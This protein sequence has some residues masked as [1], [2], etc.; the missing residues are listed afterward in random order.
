MDETTTRKRGRD[1][2]DEEELPK[3]SS[4]PGAHSDS[5]RKPLTPPSTP[6]ATEPVP[7][8]ATSTEGPADTTAAAEKTSP[9]AA[10]GKPATTTPGVAASQKTAD[11]HQPEPRRKAPPQTAADFLKR[12]QRPATNVATKKQLKKTAK[13]KHSQPAGAPQARSSSSQS[14]PAATPATPPQQAGP[15]QWTPEASTNLA[16]A[17]EPAGS[18]PEVPDDFRL[19]MSRAAR[20]RNKATVALPADPAVA[21][22]VLFRPSEKDGSFAKESR[23]ALASAL[24]TIEGVTAVR[25]NGKRNVV[26]ADAAMQSCLEVLLATTQLRGIPVAARLPADRTR[27]T[28]FV[29]GV[30]GSHSDAELL[31][32]IQSTIPVLAATRQESTVVL[33]FAGPLPPESVSIFRLRFTVRPARPR[34][35]Q[36]KQCGRLGHVAATCRWPNSCRN[37]SRMHPATEPCSSQARCTNCGGNHPACTPACPRWQE[38]R[39]VATIL[40]TSSVPLSRHAVRT[41]VREGN[42]AAKR[43]STYAQVAAGH[44]RPAPQAPQSS[45]APGGQ[46]TA[47]AAQPAAKATRPPATLAADP[48]DAIIAS[49]QL[50]LR[51]VGE[52]LPAGSPRKSPCLQAGGLQGNKDNH[53]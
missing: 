53:G 15:R 1:S 48:R 16:G 13:G 12:N 35:L 41:M 52:L 8:A 24:A 34:P 5:K 39:K 36:C 22:T 40:A 31:E 9:S 26:A 11:S 50:T 21:G 46:P 44:R 49:L 20:R 42:P 28:G 33:R 2:E 14:A 6:A 30:D 7:A 23:L 4:G 29:H 18:T 17:S 43:V 38:E 47:P 19:V 27:S 51:A 10:P 45:A 3:Q 25:V 32:G 37:C